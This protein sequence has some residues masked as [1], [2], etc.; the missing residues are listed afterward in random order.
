MEQAV[1]PEVLKPE[2]LPGVSQLRDKI[3]AQQLGCPA[4]AE[5]TAPGVSEGRGNRIWCDLHGWF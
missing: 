5:A 3:L 2:R 1:K 4:L